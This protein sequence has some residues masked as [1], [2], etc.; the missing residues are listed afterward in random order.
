MSTPQTTFNRQEVVRA[1]KKQESARN[2]VEKEKSE[3]SKAEDVES[4]GGRNS[5][6]PSPPS[7]PSQLK[8]W[9]GAL[10]D[11]SIFRI[12]LRPFPFLLSPVV[13]WSQLGPESRICMLTDCI[14]L[15]PLPLTW[16]AD[17]VAK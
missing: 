1:S 3:V 17:R 10:T 16:S 8:I 7:Y 5:P 4:A 14:D 2:S 13:R 15:V 12:F 9:H 6:L 11:E